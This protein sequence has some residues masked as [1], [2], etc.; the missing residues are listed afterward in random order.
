MIAKVT[1]VHHRP[2]LIF[3]S[4]ARGEFERLHHPQ[5]E[6]VLTSVQIRPLTSLN[7]L[8]T[9]HRKLNR[10]NRLLVTWRSPTLVSNRK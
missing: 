8:H 7:N 5:L 3:S 4:R 9:V 6:L 2:N 10:G 1:F